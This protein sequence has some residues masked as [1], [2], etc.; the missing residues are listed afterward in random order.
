VG[1][2]A[3]PPG[4]VSNVLF[5]GD[6]LRADVDGRVFVRAYLSGTPECKLALN[7]TSVASTEVQGGGLYDFRF[8]PCVDSNGFDSAK[9]INFVPPDGE[10]QLMR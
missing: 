7:D 10:F 4:Q 9:V 1:T 5:A 6:V 2:Y 3:I 8:H